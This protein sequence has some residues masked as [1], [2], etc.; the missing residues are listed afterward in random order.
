MRIAGP[1]AAQLRFKLKA[2]EASTGVRS[3]V[4]Q[5]TS[6]ATEG[7]VRL[8]QVELDAGKDAEQVLELPL[9]GA[10]AIVLRGNSG[11]YRSCTDLSRPAVEISFDLRQ[12]PDFTVF[13][14]DA[15]A[16]Q[17]ARAAFDEYF[18]SIGQPAGSR[19]RL[20]SL[21]KSPKAMPKAQRELCVR[22]LTVE[23][24]RR[25]L[26]VEIE[27][28][29]AFT[30]VDPKLGLLAT[31]FTVDN[32]TT[33]ER[34]AAAG[35]DGVA[36]EQWQ[37]FK[38]YLEMLNSPDPTAP[39]IDVPAEERLIEELLP[40]FLTWSRRFFA[41]GGGVLET[42]TAPGPWLAT[43]YP[44]TSSPAYV[45]P[46]SAGVL[47]YDY[48]LADRWAHTYRFYVQPYSRYDR[49]WRSLL[50]SRILYPGQ[51][52]IE[53]EAFARLAAGQHPTGFGRPRPGRRPHLPGGQPARLAFR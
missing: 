5:T 16:Q 35:T 53:A 45:T 12:A 44:R 49:L 40:D 1:G 14:Q 24:D 36:H 29:Q 42:E 51:A 34:F 30:P 20:K 13:G 21:T 28:F 7:D 17:A 48:L 43:A 8:R 15:A 25:I 18:E 47:Q 39:H 19:L 26:D 22:A 4:V 27:P 50:Q 52:P 31:Y 3:M 41:N 37:R 11:R 23:S 2:K 10:T 46:D 33:A 32:A 6:A 38:R 9:S